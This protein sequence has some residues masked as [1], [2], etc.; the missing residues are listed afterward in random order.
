ME[1]YKKRASFSSVWVVMIPSSDTEMVP[2]CLKRKKTGEEML[3]WEVSQLAPN[4]VLRVPGTAGDQD[5]LR[6]MLMLR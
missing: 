2:V 4:A 6:C 5:L 1:K 3:V